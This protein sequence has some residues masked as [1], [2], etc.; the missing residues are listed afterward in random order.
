MMR[1]KARTR[2]RHA[3]AAF[4]AIALGLLPAAPAAAQESAGTGDAAG[5]ASPKSSW[6]LHLRTT[7]YSFQVEDP[8]APR[9]DRFGAYQDFEGAIAGF[10]GGKFS[11]RASGR[12]ADDLSLDEE[13]TPR[14]KLFSALLEAR[15]T[16]RLTAR[17]GRQLVQEGPTGL[18]LDGLWLS[19]RP[20]ARWEGRAWGGG[21]A[22]LDHV[23][24]LAKLDDDRALGARLL[25]TPCRHIRLGAGMSYRER[26]G[27]VASRLVG[28]EGAI[29]WNRGFRA[30]GRAAY[31]L[32]RESW[33]REDVTAEWRY[34][35]GAPVVSAQWIDRRPSVDQA[36]YFARFQGLERARIGRGTVRWEHPTGFGAEAEYVGAFVNRET[37]TR[38]GGAF[39]SP[40][41][42][43]GYSA[44]VGDAG[45]ESAWFGD[46]AWRAGPWLRLEGGLTFSTYAL[47]QDAPEVDER[48][49]ATWFGRIRAFPREG[50]GLLF[51]VQN[52]QNPEFS[53]DT[54]VLLGLDLTVGRGASS[55]G[56]G[57]G[58]WFR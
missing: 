33:D 47:M 51:E 40:I 57:R 9:L 43:A 45:E 1:T 19:M 52:L 50:M 29:P 32:A 16:P 10:G 21:R 38:V 56:L 22:P 44:R 36:S 4:A 5:Y 26:G 28:V 8:G 25:A 49:L 14:G 41:G 55:F 3:V 31:D 15:P 53:H 34:R 39:L 46:L 30:S 17:L 20:N 42:R 48:D 6:W 18:T 11:L 7:G 58:G 12:F 13:T 23:F 24:N 2:P 27:L 54:R 37:S 35:P